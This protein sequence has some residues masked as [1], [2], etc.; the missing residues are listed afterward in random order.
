MIITPRVFVVAIATGLF[1]LLALL[2]ALFLV[3]GSYRGHT[4]MLIAGAVGGVVCI[5]IRIWFGRSQES[6][7]AWVQNRPDKPAG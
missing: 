1:W 6:V 7:R 2:S 5:G 3:G 4:P